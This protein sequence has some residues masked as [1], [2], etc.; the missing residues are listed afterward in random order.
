[1][2]QAI[3]LGGLGSNHNNNCCGSVS[4]D[5]P[6]KIL[7]YMGKIRNGPLPQLFSYTKAI[8]SPSKNRRIEIISQRDC[9]SV[10]LLDWL[11][12]SVW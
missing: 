8:R 10:A 6:K 5:I 11:V 2:F 4:F 7:L 12:A 1:M 9:T 3:Y